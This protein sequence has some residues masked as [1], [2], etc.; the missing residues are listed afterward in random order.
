M[1]AGHEQLLKSLGSIDVEERMHHHE[2]SNIRPLSLTVIEKLPEGKT[3]GQMQAPLQWIFSHTSRFLGAVRI[4]M[5]DGEGFLLIQKGKP[6]AAVFQHPLKALK[7]PSALKYF[8][9]QSVIDFDLRKYTPTEMQAAL[10]L[11]TEESLIQM[12]YEGMSGL[13]SEQHAGELVPETGSVT[14]IPGGITGESSSYRL[15][16]PLSCAEPETTPV[17]QV[18]QHDG[19][20]A[21]A[22]FS[23]G[24]CIFSEGDIDAEYIVAVAED[25]LR[26]AITLESITKAGSAVQ[27]TT[28]YRGGNVVITPY[29]D[30]YL[31]ILTTPEVQYGQIRRIIRELQHDA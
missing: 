16:P 4:T 1:D 20:V 22:Q 18:L 26:W 11:C 19:I 7:G 24:L 2:T 29:G 21:V 31:C 6:L 23:E 14:I 12:N 10:K 9:T 28:F 5:Q 17:M 13:Q 15:T 27:I 30:D 25:L 8:G 3:L